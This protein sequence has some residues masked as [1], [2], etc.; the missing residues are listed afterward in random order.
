MTKGGTGD[1]L[2]CLCGALLCRVPAFDA[3]AAA[4][5]TLGKSGEAVADKYG[6]GLLASDLIPAIAR[7]MKEEM[8]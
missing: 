8:E 5:Y 1:L 7:V 6:D 2:A 4:A 3:A